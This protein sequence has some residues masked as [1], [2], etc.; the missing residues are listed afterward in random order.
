[1]IG[2]AQVRLIVHL[3]SKGASIRAIA[4]VAGVASGTVQQILREERLSLWEA[5]GGWDVD[6][7]TWDAHKLTGYLNERAME[8]DSRAGEFD[9]PWPPP[10]VQGLDG[11]SYP[12]RPPKPPKR[13]QS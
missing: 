6:R 1:V 5:S 12:S 4:K 3:R 13:D 11:K 8:S 7:G 10:R 9:T 2:E